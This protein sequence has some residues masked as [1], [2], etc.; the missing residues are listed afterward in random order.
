MLRANEIEIDCSSGI[1]C[2]KLGL[3]FRGHRDEGSVLLNDSSIIKGN[4][5][6][7]LKFQVDAD[8]NVLKEHLKTASHNATYTSK[9]TQKQMIVIQCYLYQQGNT[10]QYD[11]DIYNATYTARKHKTR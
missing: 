1:F 8:D 5:Q 2:G 11:C 9:E 4:F 6:S 3:A 10:K 7:L